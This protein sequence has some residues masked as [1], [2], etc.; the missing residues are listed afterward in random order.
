MK[1]LFA[2]TN[3]GKI[4]EMRRL[5]R[6]FD[7]ATPAELGLA[8]DVAENGA[9]FFENARLKAR[10]YCAASGFPAI[11][12]DSGLCVRAL[13]GAPGIYSAR[14][15]AAEGIDALLRKLEGAEDRQ[16]SFVCSIVCAYPDGRSL[17]A[18]GECRGEIARAPRGAFGFGYD[19]VFEVLGAGRTMAEMTAEEKDALSHRG[20][21]ARSLARKLR[22]NM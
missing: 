9:T 5:L 7:I 22:G 11:A 13:G 15:L 1:Y 21:A 12:D 14:T 20:I 2:T 4:V 3:P 8:L 6:D 16:A 18:E 17:S 10:A 19:P